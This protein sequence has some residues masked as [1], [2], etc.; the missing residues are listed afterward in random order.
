MKYLRK[1]LLGVLVALMLIAATALLSGC[2]DAVKEAGVKPAAAATV[3]PD[4]DNAE[5]YPAETNED[6]YDEEDYVEE[7]TGPKQ[8]AHS[9]NEWGKD[10]GM[11]VKV[12]S[13]EAVDSIPPAPPTWLND[14][15]NDKS[16]STLI[17]VH[18][19]IA[20]D[21]RKAID[22]LCAVS[23]FVLLDQ[24]DRNFDPIDNVIDTNKNVCDDGIQ[25]GFKASYVLGY[26]LP[27]SSEIG[28]LVV[29]NGDSDS[30]YDGEKSEL[31]FTP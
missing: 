5:D 24:K 22:P 1:G 16:G 12:T 21:T 6:T 27:P 23:S 19:E 31:V 9:L 13:M 4:T 8:T 26:R 14:G 29:W 25:P 30:D 18:L 17:A 2:G 7:D 15:I 20:N 3:T 11:K 10:E 28:G